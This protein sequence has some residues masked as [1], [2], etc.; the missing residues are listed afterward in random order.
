[1]V[2]VWGAAGV[3]RVWGMWGREGGGG[4]VDCHS[5]VKTVVLFLA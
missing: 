4:E 2:G 3:W 1:M 5:T